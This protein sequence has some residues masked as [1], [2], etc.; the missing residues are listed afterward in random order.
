M[1]NSQGKFKIGALVI[2]LVALSALGA[3]VFFNKDRIAEEVALSPMVLSE[4]LGDVDSYEGVLT[5]QERADALSL[6]NQDEF[7]PEDNERASEIL[8][9]ISEYSN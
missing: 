6:L 3:L 5:E 4:I 9:I 2:A 8:E 7:T 1:S